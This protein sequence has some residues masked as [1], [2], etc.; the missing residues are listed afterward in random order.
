MSDEQ[1]TKCGYNFMD[2]EEYKDVKF[3]NSPFCKFNGIKDVLNKTFNDNTGKQISDKTALC[4]FI[5][6]FDNK[7]L[8]ELPYFNCE[9]KYPDISIVY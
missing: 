6:T 4:D 5:D 1:F 8:V 9:E 3:C 7:V 2:W